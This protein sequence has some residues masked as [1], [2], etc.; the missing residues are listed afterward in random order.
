MQLRNVSVCLLACWF[1][2]GKVASKALEDRLVICILILPLEVVTS[3]SASF[4]TT[5]RAFYVTEIFFPMW[6]NYSDVSLPN[7]NSCF[8]GFDYAC[9]VNFHLS[10][11]L[12]NSACPTFFITSKLRI[13]SQFPSLSSVPFLYL[14]VFVLKAA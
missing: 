12:P 2:A 1:A 5:S 9:S 4:Y 7:L 10:D 8:S 6:G 14:L 3:Q 13:N 11:M